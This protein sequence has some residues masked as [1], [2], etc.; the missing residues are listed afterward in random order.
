[1]DSDDELLMMQLDQEY[2]DAEADEEEEELLLVIGCILR[3]RAR[4]R[5]PRCGGSRKGKKPNKDRNR[6][7]GALMLDAD[8]FVDHP[9]HGSEIF[10]R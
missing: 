4:L 1:M 5:T 7:A 8:Y 2:A 6:Y 3:R 9:L 10:R